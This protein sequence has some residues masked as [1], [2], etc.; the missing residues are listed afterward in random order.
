MINGEAQLHALVDGKKVIITESTVRRDLQLGDKEGIECLPN[1][2]IFE[3]LTLI[4]T[5]ASTIICLATNQKFNFSKLIFES[6]VRNLDN[7]SGKF[8][9]YPR[10]V[11]VFVNQQ[12]DG[13]PTHKRMYIAPSH[14]KKIFRNMK[15]VGKGFSRNVTPLFP[16]MVVQNQAQIG[17]G[18]A[19]Q[20]DPH[21]IPIITQT[22]TYT[23]I[24]QPTTS[25]PQKKQPRKPKRKVTEVPQPSKPIHVADEVV[26]KELGDRLVT[27]ATTASS[28]GKEQDSGNIAKT[29]SKAT[30]NEH[31][32]H[33]T[34]S[35][36]GP[37][38]Q[39]TMGGTAAQ[40]R[41]ESVSK[42]SNDSLLARGNIL[43]C[44]KDS[45]KLNELME[46]CTNIQNRVLDLEK[47]KTSQQSRIA[48]LERKVKKLER[49]KRSRSHG[50]KRLYKV[51]LTAKI[52]SSNEDLGEDASKQGRINA[53]D[54]NDDITLVSPLVDEQ[55]VEMFDK[56]ED[57]LVNV[58]K[59]GVNVSEEV[60]EA[61]NTA[62]LIVDAAQVSAAGIQVSVIGAAKT[63]SAATTITVATTVEEI[64]LDQA[65]EK[66]KSTKP[67]QKGVVIQEREQEPE[68]PLK[69]KDQIKLDEETAI[70]LQAEFD[71]EERLAKEEAEKIEKANIALINTWD[72][73]QAMI[74]ADYQLAERLQAE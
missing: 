26:R 12:V 56:E 65:L 24:I 71:E 28:L 38:C 30:P 1:T 46:L 57:V 7:M 34:S 19:N 8:L 36:G 31:G 52:E 67:K 50:L 73:I 39:E 51:G 10:F 27:V 40:T 2:T 68:K 47:T 9:M 49:R 22:S 72:D 58:V 6:M 15:R 20:T 33:G 63:V 64:T 45:M 41:F 61:I 37:R 69:K 55:D 14:S 48:S 74:D 16:T 4:S 11:Q 13:M 44:D 3:Q 21:H 59:D 25:Q 32:S 35:G 5:M 66:R 43:R 53:I 17:E 60:V 29:R 18:S 54:V 62:K 42:L 23:T 70:R